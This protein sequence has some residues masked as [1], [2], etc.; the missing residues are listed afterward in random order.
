MTRHPWIAPLLIA[1][2]T[3]PAHAILR[4]PQVP[5][6]GTALQSLLNAQSQTINVATDQRQA[7]GFTGLFVTRPSTHFFVYDFG[8]HQDDLVVYDTLNPSSPLYVIS[9]ASLA[10]GWFAEV[11]FGYAPEGMVVN[12][13]DGAGAFQGTTTHLGLGFTY[14]GLAI[15]GP[16]GVFYPFD[17]QNPGQRAQ[18]LAYLGT[19][20]HL[21][22][23]WLCGE[24]QTEANGGDYDFADA[25]FLLE[26]L[27]V[28]P[29]RHTTWGAV[30]QRFR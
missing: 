10:S 5:V 20:A 16:G 15:S 30:K 4:S 11:G 26:N 2:L 22:S 24:N 23:T 17:E 8:K 1:T 29:V 18:V 3:T 25:V 6:T 21:G 27:N 19:G 14:M 9:P 28:T 12:L 13:Y 7:A